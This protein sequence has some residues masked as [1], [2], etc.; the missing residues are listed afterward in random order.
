MPVDLYRCAALIALHAEKK[1]ELLRLAGEVDQ[2][3]FGG[4]R[5][6]GGF[7]AKVVGVLLFAC[8]GNEEGE[9]G[10]PLE[11]QRRGSVG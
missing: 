4:L 6:W 1:D 3:T 8:A 2:R 7:P 10:N 5:V 9:S 11:I